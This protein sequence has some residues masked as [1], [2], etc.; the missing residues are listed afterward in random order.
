[1][2]WL[3]TQPGFENLEIEKESFF[4]EQDPERTRAVREKRERKRE[5]KKERNR[6][7]EK[8]NRKNN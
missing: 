5:R 6:G 7:K 4:A 3:K 2:N 8:K 1:L